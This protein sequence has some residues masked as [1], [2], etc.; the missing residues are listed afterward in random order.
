MDEIE[1]RDHFLS[2]L[3]DRYWNGLNQVRQKHTVVGELDGDMYTLSIWRETQSFP[4]PYE[5]FSFSL[6]PSREES[7]KARMNGVP[8]SVFAKKLKSSVFKIS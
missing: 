2:V 7:E 1:K 5:F 8:Y 6:M 3:M 4:E